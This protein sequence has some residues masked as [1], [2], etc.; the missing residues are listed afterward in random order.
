M[1]HADYGGCEVVS[2]RRYAAP[3]TLLVV[4]GVV[5]F[6]PMPGPVTVLSEAVL[7]VGLVWLAALAFDTL[8]RWFDR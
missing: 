5:R 2:V 3:V 7:A 4:G 1:D 8:W 6:A